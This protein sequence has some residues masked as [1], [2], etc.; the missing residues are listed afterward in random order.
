MYQRMSRNGNALGRDVFYTDKAFRKNAPKGLASLAAH[1][2]YYPNLSPLRR[3]SWL[4]Q[5]IRL[6]YEFKLEDSSDRLF[7]LEVEMEEEESLRG[8]QQ[9]HSST[10][11]DQTT[12]PASRDEDFIIAEREIQLLPRVSIRA[13]EEHYR[14]VKDSGW[15]SEE[16]LEAFRYRDDFITID[17]DTT[18]KKFE[19]LLFSRNPGVQRFLRFMSWL[20]CQ[21]TEAPGPNDFHAE[22]GD[23]M[24]KWT[25]KILLALSCCVLFLG[26]VG[27]LYLV[28]LPQNGLYGVT[29]A[30]SVLFDAIMVAGGNGG[31]PV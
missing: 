17:P 4:S 26:P 12:P 3:Y 2:M 8:D 6:D 11:P 22:H 24:F 19:F 23:R 21:E 14:Q 5:M 1:Q 30:F 15:L 7:G 13:H 18:Y 29:V 9:A 27:I 31:V 28:D 10:P 25:V 20:F 16:Q